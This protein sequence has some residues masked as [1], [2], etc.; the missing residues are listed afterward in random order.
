MDLVLGHP[1]VTAAIIGT[2]NPAH[3]RGNVAA[4]RRALGAD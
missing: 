2:I 4:A 1:G 3:L